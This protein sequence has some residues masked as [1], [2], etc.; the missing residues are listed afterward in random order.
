[1]LLIIVGT[2]IALAVFL[3]VGAF[4]AP[5]VALRKYHA[6]LRAMPAAGLALEARRCAEA[7]GIRKQFPD[8]RL[9]RDEVPWTWESLA[10]ALDDLYA[11]M[12]AQDARNGE[13]GQG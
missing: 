7:A 2:I 3:I 5:Q 4:V 13:A 8:A 10:K 6:R 11:S 12:A 1:M 9:F